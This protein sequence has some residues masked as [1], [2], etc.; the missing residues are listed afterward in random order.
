LKSPRHRSLASLAGA[1]SLTVAEC[2]GEVEWPPPFL[3]SK[4]P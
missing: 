1:A 2:T 3:S 4:T